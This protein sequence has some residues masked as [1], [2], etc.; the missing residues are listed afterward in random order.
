[1]ILRSFYNGAFSI[2]SKHD[3]DQFFFFARDST[4]FYQLYFLFSERIVMNSTSNLFKKGHNIDCNSYLR[5]LILTK[6]FF[7]STV[8][9]FSLRICIIILNN[10]TS[11]SK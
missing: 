5:Y 3:F 10:Q 1:M 2:V 8:D 4:L 7:D 11:S 9:N 6:L